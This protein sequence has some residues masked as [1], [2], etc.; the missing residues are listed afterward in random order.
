MRNKKYRSGFVL[1][2]AV[3]IALL[4]LVG[5]VIADKESDRAIT[6]FIYTDKEVAKPCPEC[7]PC[8]D[9]VEFEKQ[10]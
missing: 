8:K 4:S 5:T 7:K 1:T 2:E 9:K 10:Y 3:L 6:E